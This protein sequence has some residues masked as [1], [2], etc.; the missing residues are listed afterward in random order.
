M[1]KLLTIIVPDSQPEHLLLEEL[2]RRGFSVN[3]ASQGDI[4]AAPP[5]GVSSNQ[6][7]SDLLSS[8]LTEFES[9]LTALLLHSHLKRRLLEKEPLSA[10]VRQKLREVVDA[11]ERRLQKVNRLVNEL[12]CLAQVELEEFPWRVEKIDLCQTLRNAAARAAPRIRALGSELTARL[13]GPILGQWHQPRLEQACA[14]LLVSLVLEFPGRLI[15]V[16]SSHDGS[17]ARITFALGDAEPGDGAS[18]AASSPIEGPV[19]TEG[20]CGLHTLAKAVQAHGGTLSIEKEPRNG[21][22]TLVI[23]LLPM[24]DKE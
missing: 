24:P 23:A 16:A 11:E 18:K 2:H 14:C 1:P 20:L 7:R 10:S 17:W 21:A 6:G 13:A 3:F 4:R 8:L 15:E 9:P 19:F 22:T 5:E 12:I